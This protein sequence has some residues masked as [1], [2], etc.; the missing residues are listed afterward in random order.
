MNNGRI[1]GSA[2]ILVALFAVAAGWV[3]M[4]EGKKNLKQ[5]QIYKMQ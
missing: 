3:L 1:K 2:K 5:A 4:E